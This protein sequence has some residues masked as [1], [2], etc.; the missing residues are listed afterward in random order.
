MNLKKTVS[1]I[2]TVALIL[3]AVFAVIP[4][5]NA[6]NVDVSLSVK[7]NTESLKEGGDVEF[8]ISIQ[9]SGD[10][11]VE[12]AKLTYEGDVITEVG[13]INAGD[14][15]N[16]TETINVP[17]SKLGDT[18]AFSVEF[19]YTDDTGER[20][21]DEEYATAK[22]NKKASNVKVGT[23]VKVD[24]D[25]VS[26]GGKV[27]FTFT[28]ENQGDVEITDAAVSASVL[29]SGN[30]IGDKFS[31]DPG[32]SKSVTYTGT[33]NKTVTVKPVV[34]YT[35]DGKSY[36]ADFDSKKITV[37]GDADLH[38]EF[39]S[40]KDVYAPG[41]EATFKL[42]VENSGDVLLSNIKVFDYNGQRVDS[43]RT[44]LSPGES[45]NVEK[46]VNIQ[47]GGELQFTVEATDQNGETHTFTSNAIPVST[48]EVSASPS[49]SPS[50][51][52]TSALNEETF[53]IEVTSE[54]QVMEEPGLAKVNMK[55]TNNSDV[56][57]NNVVVEEATL[58]KIT[59]DIPSIEPGQEVNIE[60]IE[61]NV[62]ET[63]V[64]QFVITGYDAAGE[65]YEFAAD[66][67]E[68]T[69]GSENA[70]SGMSTVLIIII[71]VIVLIIVIGVILIVLVRKEK[72]KQSGLTKGKNGTNMPK[73][74]MSRPGTTGNRPQRPTSA[75]RPSQYQGR[76][77]SQVDRTIQR[78]RPMQKPSSMQ[79]PK[80]PTEDR[81][82]RNRFDD[83]NNF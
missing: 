22:V 37:S 69:V 79:R 52:T 61:I 6:A 71:V 82:P 83:R 31:L 29:N 53:V 46:T 7:P 14:T 58:G 43:A 65:K 21:Q 66:P 23:S 2:L 41:E 60:N 57:L 35:A 55:I 63:T 68:I 3:T 5:A 16:L 78:P 27:K 36:S 9:N 74:N 11:A 13:N 15:K 76:N 25:T 40:D 48:G 12:E 49:A 42:Y 20:R 72:K 54:N 51:S 19:Y 44:E 39:S 67:F 64:Y 70:G 33:F 62:E 73:S 28:V 47:N 80:D 4:T 38:L 45:F 8:A 50:A 17:T 24:K 30:R 32:Q 34:K 77:G 10:V 26:P 75:Q 81:K 1:F 59:E 56:V 18:L